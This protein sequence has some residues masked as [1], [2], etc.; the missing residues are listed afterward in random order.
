LNR[1]GLL[2]D[3]TDYPLLLV[4]MRNK[5]LA[6]SVQQWMHREFSCHT[7]NFHVSC[8]T[9]SAL[10]NWWSNTLIND[11]AGHIRPDNKGS[12]ELSYHITFSKDLSSLTFNISMPQL[13]KMQ[14][15]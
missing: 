4:Q 11:G 9:L 8:G 5:K 12:L 1:G 6:T 3:A 13:L 2:V 15:L 14:K 10:A 7:T